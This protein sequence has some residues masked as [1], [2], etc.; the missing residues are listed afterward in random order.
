MSNLFGNLTTTGLEQQEDRLGGGFSKFETDAYDAKIK[1]AYAGQSDGGARNVTVVADIG[2][3]EYSETIYITNKQGENF[4]LN[5]QDT[6]KKVALPGFTTINDIC[7][8]CTDEGA[9]EFQPAEEKVVNIYDYELKRDV[10]KSVMVLTSLTGKDVTLGIQKI[11]ENK[12]EKKGNEYVPIADT[13]ETNAIQKVFHAATKMTVLE[14]Q[15]GATEAAF[16]PAWVDKNKGQTYDKRSI[17][18]G[19]GGKT[20]GGAPQAGATAPRTSLFGKS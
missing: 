20:A 15:Q 12:N 8:V 3:K 6:T 14:A 5:K 2:G 17:K 16:Y 11:L 13:R 4:F 9:L 7:L 18:D 1:V 19:Q 10:P